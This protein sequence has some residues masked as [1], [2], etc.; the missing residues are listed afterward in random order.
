MRGLFQAQGVPKMRRF[1][2]WRLIPLLFGLACAV[3]VEAAGRAR[4]APKPSDP[5]LL[6]A[7]QA[8]AFANDGEWDAARGMAARSGN[9]L[10]AKLV[11]W[12]RLTAPGVPALA[13]VAAFLLENSDW[14]ED[15]FLI[16]RAEE[17][18]ADGTVEAELTLRWFA[19]FPPRL[20]E[21]QIRYGELLLARGLAEDRPAAEG[22][23]RAGWTGADVG[24]QRESDIVERH[25]AI[26][27]RAQHAARLDRLLWENKLDAASRLLR[28]VSADDRVVA[29]ARMTLMTQSGDAGAHLSR[30]PNA[31]QRDPGLI[32]ERARH[33]R[34]LGRD[35]E[36]A[37]ILVAVPSSGPFAERIWRERHT[38]LRR[39]L[40]KGDFELAYRLAQG[41]GVDQGS[42]FADA[43]FLAGWI[44]L[45]FLKRTEP[46][47]T[48]FTALHAGARQPLT[49]ARAAYWAGLTAET[50]GNRSD[51]GAWLERAAGFPTTFFGQLAVARRAGN[52]GTLGLPAPA[53]ANDAEREVFERRELIRA[54][55][56]LHAIGDARRVRT[57]LLR[58]A[59][60]VQSPGEHALIGELAQRLGRP[61]LEV[62]A[63]KRA[64]RAGQMP[65]VAGYPVIAT[66][67]E[68][69]I[70][71]A[72]I[73][74][75]TRQE[76]EFDP[77]AISR[78]GA[79][80]LMQLMP[81]TAREVAKQIKLPYAEGKLTGD[82]S[83][84]MRLGSQY[85][86]DMTRR[87][88]GSYIL[89]AAAYNAGPSR[90][91][92][93]IRE[94]GDPR[95]P[96]VDPLDWIELIPIEE[97]RNYVQ[98]VI[99]N[100]QVYRQRLAA[101]PVPVQIASD[102]RRGQRQN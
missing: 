76:S 83:Y 99:E 91:Q 42:A 69:G 94:Y 4:P 60:I 65:S 49:V 27:G 67:R 98:R 13:E 61:E 39:A 77:V 78:A 70:E 71:P 51:A 63:S 72:M 85:L 57:F 8:I 7:A 95:D 96:A 58:T 12:L 50:M 10:L 79:R 89:A 62:I 43:E 31:L 20:P 14:P 46:A 25:A 97:T 11:E 47:L 41:H 32:Y 16:R 87:F 34:R 86:E 30:V 1:A 59:E 74:A 40:A 26:L 5:A 15:R 93:W 66:P 81:R 52:G 100:L 92:Q 53:Q 24:A 101:R 29:E 64:V 37:Q 73:L 80:G 17:A 56:L 90:A 28:L 33:A 35:D 3:A 48:H 21:S 22:W 45:R 88:G 18:I 75:I 2:M 102:L 44:A 19:D 84:N 36:A 82:P 54:A 55:R 9:P 6:T 23:I 68:A 38:L